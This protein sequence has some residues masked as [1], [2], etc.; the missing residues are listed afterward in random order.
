MVTFRVLCF[1][2]FPIKTKKINKG[3]WKGALLSEGGH[4]S[5]LSLLVSWWWAVSTTLDSCSHQGGG[6][7]CTHPHTHTRKQTYICW[8]VFALSDLGWHANHR[9]LLW[10]QPSQTLSYIHMYSMHR[11][12]KSNQRVVLHDSRQGRSLLAKMEKSCSFCERGCRTHFSCVV[13]W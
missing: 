12:R 4:I 10:R 7:V 6:N 9:V 5:V 13:T 11:H 1:S 8:Y 3:R 2:F